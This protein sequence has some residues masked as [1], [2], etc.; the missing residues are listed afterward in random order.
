MSLFPTTPSPWTF[1]YLCW[2]C[3]E[4]RMNGI[5][6]K[7]NPK[8]LL[9]GIWKSLYYAQT[10]FNILIEKIFQKL[11]KRMSIVVFKNSQG[12]SSLTPSKRIISSLMGWTLDTHSTASIDKEN[13]C[14]TSCIQ[15]KTK[16]K[17]LN[18]II[19]IELTIECCLS[20]QK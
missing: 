15:G 11:A 3:F 5:S 6:S 18:N 7:N 10:Q 20:A 16:A 4:K 1:A 8:N 14:I 12:F 9:L 19:I 17:H 2:K 13:R